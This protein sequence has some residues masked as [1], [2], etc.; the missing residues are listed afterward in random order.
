MKIFSLFLLAQFSHLLAVDASPEIITFVQPDGSTFRGHVRGDEWAGWHETLN[1]YSCVQTEDGWWVYATGINGR[2]LI[3]G[4]QVVRATDP[5]SLNIPKHLRPERMKVRMDATPPNLQVARTDTFRVPLLLVD[6]PDYGNQYDQAVFDTL[7][8]SVGTY[9]HPGHPGSG[10]FRDFY[11]E[12]SYGQFDPVSLVDGWY[13]APHNHDYY[14]YSNPN[15]YQHV[16]TLVRAI[17]DSAEAHGMNWSQFDN[18]GDGTVDALNLLHAGPGAE[19]GDQSNIWSHKWS[20]SAANLQVQYDGVWINSYTMNPEMQSNNV[21]AIG[22]IAHEF[23]HALGL[24]DLY[25][26]DYSSSGAGKLAL[27]ASG[28]WGTAGNTPWYPSAMNAWCKTELG[29]TNV[30]PLTTDQTGITLPQSYTSN[31]IYQ[32]NHGYDTSEYWLVENRQKVGTDINMPSPGLLFWHIDT[33]KTS[34]WGVN[35]DEPHYGVGLEQA[36]GQFNLENGGGSDNGDPFPGS[37]N[38]HAFS[39]NTVPNTESYY[40]VPSM[41]AFT[42][43][44]DPDSVMTFDLAFGEYNIAQIGV[45]NNVGSA[46]AT[47]QIDLTMSNTFEIGAMNLTIEF[48]PGIFDILSVEPLGRTTVDSIIITGNHI[49]LINP[50]IAVGDGQFLRLN[51][52]TNSGI[53]GTAQVTVAQIEAW[54]ITGGGIGFQTSP[55]TYTYTAQPQLFYFSSDSGTIG[56][57]GRY[58]VYLQNPVPVKMMIVTVSDMS[59]F[60]IPMEE[61][62]TDQNGNNSWDPGEPLQDLNGDGVW[63]P[64]IEFSDRMADWNANVAY[65]VDGVQVAASTLTPMDVGDGPLFYVNNYIEPNAPSGPI[66]LDLAVSLMMDFYGNT[67]LETDVTS[68]YLVLIPNL[69]T[70]MEAGIPDYYSLSSAYPN[71]FNPATQLDYTLPEAAQVRIAI[72]SLLGQRVYSSHHTLSPGTYNF[73][74]NGTDMEH[75]RLSSGVYFIRFSAGDFQTTRKLVFM[76]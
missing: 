43:I 59:N 19:Q 6:F 55:G 40:A 39:Y 11:H 36:D 20:L 7:M 56:G 16:L 28:S 75:K 17:V 71:P 46:Y 25:D 74:W 32:I 29:W 58:A 42:N 15:G 49:E 9:G 41:I 67:G 45:E 34:G 44:S 27:M 30:I 61:I 73:R 5:A 13:T 4:S 48:D 65:T 47:G 8:N 54:T 38:N 2:H 3:P 14:A 33:E 37:T 62:Y 53:S 10:S 12:I 51:I 24:P 76:K 18:D 52:F 21:V 57:H 1:G 35:N 23:G 26:T 50:L 70:D 22:V 66:I 72:Y 63:T 64:M 68:G 69:G 31:I 60:V